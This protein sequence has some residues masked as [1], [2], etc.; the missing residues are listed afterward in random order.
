M[1]SFVLGLNLSPSVASEVLTVQAQ[2]QPQL[3][4]VAQNP[5]L[6]AEQKAATRATI[7]GIARKQ[8]LRVLGPNGFEAYEKTKASWLPPPTNPPPPE[9]A[10]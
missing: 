1:R 4:L 3:N 5:S 9:P 6:N 2:F 8:L 7:G 10:L